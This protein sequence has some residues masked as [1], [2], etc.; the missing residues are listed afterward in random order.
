MDAPVQTESITNWKRWT[1]TTRS[2]PRLAGIGS[3]HLGEFALEG[4]GGGPAVHPFH[5]FRDSFGRWISIELAFYARHMQ[6]A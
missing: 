4:G 2:A 6:P 5:L 3:R 1:L